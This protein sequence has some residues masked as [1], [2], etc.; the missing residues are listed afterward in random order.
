MRILA[1]DLSLTNS[2]W[3]CG[4]IINGKL[5]VIA[6]GSIGTKRFAKRST[7]FRLNY[8]AAELQKLYKTYKVDRVVKER[9]FSNGR[10]TSTQQL[11]KVN[12]V[13]EMITHLADH[14]GF[15]E[16]APTTVKKQLTGN[17][18]ASKEEVAAAVAT[19][20]GIETKVNDESDAIAVLISY[21]KMEGLI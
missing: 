10:I 15:T 12:G 5:K 8:I 7:G 3:C 20:T 13:Y 11:F 2:G 1:F 4:E 17:G 21:G 19:Y 18:K 16:L 14:D 9:S 6:Y